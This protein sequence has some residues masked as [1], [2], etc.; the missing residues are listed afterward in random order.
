MLKDYNIEQKGI[1]NNKIIFFSAFSL[2]VFH[3]VHKTKHLS[4]SSKD[5]TCCAKKQ[6]DLFQAYYMS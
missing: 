2:N 6:M 1:K 4:N 3:K 5:F